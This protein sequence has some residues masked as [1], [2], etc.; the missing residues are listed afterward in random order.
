MGEEASDL[1]K[2]RRSERVRSQTNEQ[3]DH[4]YTPMKK[5]A[6]PSP[7]THQDSTTT[8]AYT[9]SGTA[10]PPSQ[11]DVIPASQYM[12]PSKSAGYGFNRLSQYSPPQDQTQTQTQ[13]FSQFLPP[14]IDYEVEDEEE[15][16]VWGYMVPT[17]KRG[18][19]PL[20]LKSRSA[21]PVPE[22][23]SKKENKKVPKDEYERQEQKYE[24]TKITGL[25]SSGYLIGRHPECGMLFSTSLS[26][27]QRGG[28]QGTNVAAQIG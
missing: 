5:G 10:T 26:P 3:D 20:V 9:K 1:K 11:D 21:C 19:E 7:L 14:L 6:L 4:L 18:G 15:E 8:E 12:S 13:A 23:P 25:S 17:D 22:M 16:G 24:V 28:S 27:R 2:V